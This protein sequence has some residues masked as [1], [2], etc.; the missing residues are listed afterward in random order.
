M[1]TEN[2]QKTPENRIFATYWIETAFSLDQVLAEAGID[3]IKDDELQSD[4]PYCP[5]KARVTAVQQ[6]LNDTRTAP[7]NASCTP[8]TSP[9]T[10]TRCSNASST[11]KQTKVLGQHELHELHRPP[12]HEDR[13]QALQGRHPRPPKR[14]GHAGPQPRHG[15]VFHSL[16]EVWR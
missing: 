14:L 6:V 2:H 16:P 8:P 12:C 5:F 11:S 13:P 3:F 10:S 7:A 4:G 1:T 9:A 15:H